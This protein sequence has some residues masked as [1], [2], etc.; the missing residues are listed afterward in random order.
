MSPLGPRTRAVALPACALAALLAAC[1]GRLPSVQGLGRIGEQALPIGPDAERGIGFG[2]A[3]TVAGRYHLVSDDALTR[4]VNLVGLSVAEQSVRAGEVSFRFGVLDTDD[5]NAFAAPGGYVLIT[6]GALGLM[7]SEAEL[8]GVLAH[9]LAHVDQKHVL[10]AIRRSS[11]L[12][13]A[14]DESGLQ[15]SRLDSIAALGSTVLFTGLGR[16]DELEADSLGVLYAAAAGYRTDGLLQF[17]QHLRGAEG[18]GAS[19]V[20]ELMATHPPTADRIAAVEREV[21]ALG[22]VAG[23]DGTARFRG[24]VRGGRGRQ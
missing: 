1:G 9:E 4:Y 3:A 16:G 20:R 7:Q 21:A 5:V 12:L 6:R 11:V 15:G 23:A 19:G 8:A 10:A 17:L 13:Q 22:P 24:A 14:R 2:I 18:A